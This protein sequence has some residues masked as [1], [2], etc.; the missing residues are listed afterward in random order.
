ML[1]VQVLRDSP[2]K[3]IF[4]YESLKSRKRRIFFFTDELHTRVSTWKP[5]SPPEK[6]APAKARF[7]VPY[8]KNFFSWFTSIWVLR[9]PSRLNI[10]SYETLSTRKPCAKEIPETD[11]LTQREQYLY[12]TTLRRLKI[13]L[14]SICSKEEP[15]YCHGAKRERESCHMTSNNQLFFTS[16]VSLVIPTWAVLRS[17]AN[18]RKCQLKI[19]V[20]KKG[21]S[22]VWFNGRA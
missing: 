19:F 18:A 22:H 12:R 16:W 9:D 3:K 13:L 21:M 15:H 1:V 17:L 4:S 10:G 2:S 5:L 6:V 8:T 14:R 11:Y 20:R 7:R